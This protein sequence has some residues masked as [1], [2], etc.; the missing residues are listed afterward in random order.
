MTN[1]EIIEEFI[2][3]TRGSNAVCHIGYR[4]NRLYN[5]STELIEID[6]KA[7]R[8]KVNTA[9]YSRT[10]SRIQGT[11]MALL[12]QYGY[13]I[14]EYEGPDAWIWNYGYMGAPNLRVS[15]LP[16]EE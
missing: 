1:K 9:K 6:R 14:E 4:G 8:A 10:T 16:P 11:I 15:D 2:K 7:K 3:G 12:S 5:Y 13:E